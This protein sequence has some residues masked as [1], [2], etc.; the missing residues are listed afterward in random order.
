MTKFEYL[1]FLRELNVSYHIEK[2]T[3]YL[4]KLLLKYPPRKEPEKPKYDNRGAL[5]GILFLI[6]LTACMFLYVFWPDI[7]HRLFPPVEK[8][9]EMII[10][11]GK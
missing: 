1:E 2:L 9:M 10:Y 8:C 6:F 11:K 5:G 4:E 3:P 7:K